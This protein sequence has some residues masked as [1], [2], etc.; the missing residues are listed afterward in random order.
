MLFIDNFE[1]EITRELAASTV[2]GVTTPVGPIVSAVD[3][4]ATVLGPHS[5]AAQ[6]AARA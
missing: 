6:Y 1:H 3:P 4:D 2:Y 5:V